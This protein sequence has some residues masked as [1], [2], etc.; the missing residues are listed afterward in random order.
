MNQK[1]GLEFCSKLESHF[2]QFIRTTFFCLLSPKLQS[3][4][5][6]NN[7]RVM[8]ATAICTWVSPCV[9]NWILILKL[10]H[11][12]VYSVSADTIRS[13][14][15]PV[16]LYGFLKNRDAQR[17]AV[18]LAPVEK[19]VSL[20]LWL[21]SPWGP[22]ADFSGRLPTV[23]LKSSMTKTLSLCLTFIRAFSKSQ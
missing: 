11:C 9:Q 15:C 3:K 17:E 20:S 2:W 1:S 22:T 18:Y 13:L 23:T 16:F 8:V 5:D 21:P 6:H 10:Q 12:I 14:P 4:P 19:F 7:Y